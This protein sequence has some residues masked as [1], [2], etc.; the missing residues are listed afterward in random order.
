M[1]GWLLETPL[2][3]RVLRSWYT[4]GKDRIG[5]LMV[6]MSGIHRAI[7]IETPQPTDSPR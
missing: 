4:L 7:V 6:E 5:K 2:R 3:E 1:H